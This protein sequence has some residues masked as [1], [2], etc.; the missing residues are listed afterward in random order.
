[1]KMNRLKGIVL[2]VVVGLVV[3]TG[4]ADVVGSPPDP[5]PTATCPSSPPPFTGNGEGSGCS[6]NCVPFTGGC[7]QYI[8]YRENGVLKSWKKCHQLLFCSNPLGVP[9]GFSCNTVPPGGGGGVPI[10]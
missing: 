1:M 8:L 7:C 3:G 10:D 2:A 4:F 5:D 9:S 6:S